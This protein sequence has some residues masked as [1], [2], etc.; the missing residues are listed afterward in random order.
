MYILFI[1]ENVSAQPLHKPFL[2]N[3]K[4]SGP[5]V[6]LVTTSGVETGGF[7]AAI[8][9]FIFSLFLIQ[10]RLVYHSLPVKQ[11]TSNC[12]SVDKHKILRF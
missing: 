12:L 8:N 6:L 5:Y 7:D 2:P 9:K 1:N 11:L 4:T 10:V 3:K